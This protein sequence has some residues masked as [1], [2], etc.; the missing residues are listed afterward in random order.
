[1]FNELEDEE[2]SEVVKRPHLTTSA[3]KKDLKWQMA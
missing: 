3:L 1:M 2:A